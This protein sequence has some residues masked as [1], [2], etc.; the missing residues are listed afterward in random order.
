MELEFFIGVILLAVSVFWV[1]NY[2]KR[3]KKN[4]K[5]KRT[6][7]NYIGAN[8]TDDT[9]KRKKRQHQVQQAFQKYINNNC[10]SNASDKTYCDCV[11]T[12]SKSLFRTMGNQ[13]CKFFEKSGS[14]NVPRVNKRLCKACRISLKSL[15]DSQ[16]P[17]KNSCLYKVACKNDTCTD[18]L[19]SMCYK[20]GGT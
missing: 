15:I 12:Q 10:D 4:K 2:T 11:K 17:K 14:K 8:S 18:I 3:Q 7:Q 9:S 16:H 1:V 20:A 19:P 5:Y 6:I 13:Q